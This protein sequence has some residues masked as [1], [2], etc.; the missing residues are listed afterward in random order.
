MVGNGWQPYRNSGTTSRVQFPKRSQ[1]VDNGWQPYRNRGV[2]FRYMTI[3]PKRKT[4]YASKAYAQSNVLTTVGKNGDKRFLDH[5]PSSVWCSSK[6]HRKSK[7]IQKGRS[8][9]KHGR[10]SDRLVSVS[11]QQATSRKG[12]CRSQG[13]M[14]N[15][16]NAVLSMN[17]HKSAKGESRKQKNNAV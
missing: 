6:F 1:M 14:I 17:K 7:H 9:G 11:P 15:K 16:S 13:Q 4:S 12:F 10:N 8:H 3:A 2:K 5:G